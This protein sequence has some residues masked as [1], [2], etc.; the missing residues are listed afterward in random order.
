MHQDSLKKRPKKKGKQETAKEEWEGNH[1]WKPWDR[2]KD[3]TAG[4]Q[5]VKLDANNMAQGL[6][7]RQDKVACWQE[8][9]APITL[10]M[11]SSRLEGNWGTS[12]DP[13]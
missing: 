3:L 1:P 9:L 12:T 10:V 11:G 5:N 7:S 6:S 4:R 2:E 8:H 13:P